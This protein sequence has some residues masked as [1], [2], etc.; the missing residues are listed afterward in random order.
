M[1]NNWPWFIGGLQT[2]SLRS[3]PATPIEQIN[4]MQSDILA[5]AIKEIYSHLFSLL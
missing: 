4:N 2:S 5:N 1:Q 3:S